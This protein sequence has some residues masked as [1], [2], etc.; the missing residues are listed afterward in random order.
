MDRKYLAFDIETAKEVPGPDFNWRPHRPLGISCAA[1]LSCDGDGP[2]LRYGKTADG[3]PSPRMSRPEAQ[4]L[5]R[6]L[7]D[8]VE[9]GYTLL[10]WNGLGFDLDVLAEESGLHKECVD[11][12]VGHV[13]MMFHVFCDRGFPVG[14]DAAA[15]AQRIPGKPAGM[16]GILAPQLWAQGRHQEVLDYVSQDVRI[17]LDIARLCDRN[18]KF[19]WVTRKGKVSSFGLPEGWL[20]VRDALRLPLPDT[21]WMDSPMSRDGYTDWLKAR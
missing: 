8:L 9:K 1:V 4:A 5:V 10:T 17:A 21:S 7:S 12:A 13:D 18:R 19:Q 14:L 16:S 6:E 3:R 11:L 2:L 15:K 20:A